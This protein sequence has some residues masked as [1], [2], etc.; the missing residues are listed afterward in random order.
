MARSPDTRPTSLRAVLAVSFLCSLGTGV[1]W[2]GVPFIAKHAY[3]FTQTR[4]LL[5]ALAMGLV[6]MA[7]AFT[8]GRVTRWV[9]RW[10]SPRGVLDACVIVVTVVCLGPVVFRG[11]RGEPALWVAALVGTYLYS[12]LWPLLE[13][14]LTAGRH[15]AQMR[16]AIGWFNL[17][18]ASAVA[19]PLFLMAPIL[20]KHGEWTIGAFAAT[21]LAAWIVLRWFER[22]PSECP[23]TRC[24]SPYHKSREWRRYC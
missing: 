9:E 1:F 16:S 2:H 6:Y 7:G 13:S 18:W 11:E 10:L 23:S 3:D 15:G 22:Y 14:Y 20:E 12:L 4:N 8:A 5:L 17:T 24:R 19:I 21:T